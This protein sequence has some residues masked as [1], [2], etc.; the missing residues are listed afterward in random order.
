MTDFLQQGHTYSN[1]ATPPNSTTHYGSS[2]QTHESLGA[3]TYSNH[4]TNLSNLCALGSGEI[5]DQ[6]IRW[7]K[8]GRYLKL[9]LVST[10]KHTHVHVD[11][12]TPAHTQVNI[13]CYKNT[14][15][16]FKLTLGL[17]IVVHVCNPNTQ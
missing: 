9:Y 12:N 5:L 15:Q 11:S 4:H 14:Y 16:C 17:V 2:I 3:I 1:E 8:L 13:Y 7:G 6:R 10:C